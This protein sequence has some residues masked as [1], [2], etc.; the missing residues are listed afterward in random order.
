MYVQFERGRLEQV[1]PNSVWNGDVIPKGQSPS[2]VAT[3]NEPVAVT[4]REQQLEGTG[5]KVEITLV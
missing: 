2:R 1:H 3:N 5:S 4:T